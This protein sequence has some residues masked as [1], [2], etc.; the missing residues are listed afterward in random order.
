VNLIDY[1]LRPRFEVLLDVAWWRDDQAESALKAMER[2]LA[3]F[4]DV[5]IKQ[6]HVSIVWDFRTKKRVRLLTVLFTHTGTW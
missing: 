2:A 6:C 4:A 1:L 5:K 3:P